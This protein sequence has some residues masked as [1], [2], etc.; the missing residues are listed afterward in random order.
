MWLIDPDKAKTDFTNIFLQIF[1][2]KNLFINDN[3]INDN[4]ITK[5]NI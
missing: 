1:T 5:F 3:G 2:V 4:Y